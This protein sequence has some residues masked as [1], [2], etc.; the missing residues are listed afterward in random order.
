[1]YTTLLCVLVPNIYTDYD[2]VH[3]LNLRRKTM[4][5]PI[6]QDLKYRYTC[7]KYDTT[8]KVP[9]KDLAVLF[10][11]M[12]LSPSSIN[13][14][15]WKYIVLESNT[16]KKRMA[17]TFV[18]KFQFNLPHIFESS[19][20]I[21]FGHH[22]SYQRSDYEKVINKDIQNKRTKP[23]N[24]ENAFGAFGFVQM[25]TDA[26]GNTSNWTKAQTYLA[27]GNTLHTLARL[28]IDSTPLEGVDSDLI[29][30]E[31]KQ[32]LDGY[33]CEV[34]LAIGYH[35]PTEDYNINFPKSRLDL[36]DILLRL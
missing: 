10:E 33:Q 26:N 14:Q 4:T 12:R 30:K 2:F 22:A 17:K 15:P 13:S 23:E 20:V 19:H 31:F 8:K 21:L 36:N 35:H 24:K 32:E 29:A 3:T 11:A 16:A 5:H 34:A 9:D 25:N 18:N 28:K 1:M 27:L 6:L 7:K